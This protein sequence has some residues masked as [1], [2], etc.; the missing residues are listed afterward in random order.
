MKNSDPG[1]TELGS[2]S[3]LRLGQE[4]KNL[5]IKIDKMMCT[6]HKRAILSAV[7]VRKGYVEDG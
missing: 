4:L 5:G 2:Q 1:L 3:C 6:G 7:E